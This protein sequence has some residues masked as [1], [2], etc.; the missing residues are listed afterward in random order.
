MVDLRK[1]GNRVLEETIFRK[2]HH[3]D[4]PTRQGGNRSRIAEKHFVVV[5]LH[6]GATVPTAKLFSLYVL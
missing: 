2:F 5:L 6:H 4:L 1:A 3:R